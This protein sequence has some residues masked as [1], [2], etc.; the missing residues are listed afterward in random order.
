MAKRL[1]GQRR[2]LPSWARR[3]MNPN[4]PTL[5]NKT[6]F[7]HSSV[8]PKTGNEILYPTVRMGSD[9][10]LRQLGVRAAKAEAL[11]KRDYISFGKGKAGSDAATAYSKQLSRTIGRA[12]K[13]KP[14]GAR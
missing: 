2:V 10:K 8:H 4:T 6:V 9:G 5:G 7:S 14:S 13:M 3:A 12:R 1:V 11:K